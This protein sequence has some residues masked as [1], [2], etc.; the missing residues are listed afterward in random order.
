MINALKNNRSLTFFQQ[1]T[2]VY[3]NEVTPVYTGGILAPSSANFSHTA[4]ITT[5]KFN[6]QLS[7]YIEMCRNQQEIL[8]KKTSEFINNIKINNPNPSISQLRDLSTWKMVKKLVTREELMKLQISGKSDLPLTSDQL[9]EIAAAI[10]GKDLANM[11]DTDIDSII[12]AIIKP[13]KMQYLN[14]LRNFKESGE[15]SELLQKSKLSELSEQLKNIDLSKITSKQFKDLVDK[16]CEKIVYHHLESISSDPNKQSLADNIEPLN[17]SEHIKKHFD[18]EK[19]AVDYK[20]P[21]NEKPLNRE[22][23]MIKG[24]K[25]RV[26]KNELCGIGIAAA[27]GAGV[28]FT[29]GFAISLAQ[30]GISPESLKFAFASGGNGAVESGALSAVGYGIGRTIGE[31]ASHA[32]AGLLQN[33]GVTITENISKMVNMGVVGVLTTAVFSAYQFIKLKIK[34]VATRE[35][36]IQVGKQA[37]FS[38]SLLAVSIVAQGICGGAAGIIVSVSAGI[39]FITYSVV[40]SV[41]QRHFAEKIRVYTIEKCYPIFLY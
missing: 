3:Q 38:L 10:D 13:D 6:K 11:Y 34:G 15:I 22:K 32:V 26:L 37:L 40:D 36:L 1:T 7:S 20:K 18:P 23:D 33:I 4:A 25:M 9:E 16:Y 8:L 39:I 12:N 30:T 41:H 2:P 28:G 29:I 27:I 21:V 17:S 19:K 35:A 31:V 14:A 5:D 24:N